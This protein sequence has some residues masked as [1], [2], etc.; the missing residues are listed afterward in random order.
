ML[1]SDTG[2]Y[3]YL[4]GENITLN[5][6]VNYTETESF[7]WDYPAKCNSTDDCQVYLTVYVSDGSKFRIQL[8]NQ[9]QL[10][11]KESDFFVIIYSSQSN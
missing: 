7:L 11:V 4:R 8:A 3:H 10:I 5:C 1:S 2:R 9:S 6:T